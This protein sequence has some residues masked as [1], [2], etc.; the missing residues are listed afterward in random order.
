VAGEVRSLRCFVCGSAWCGVLLY[1]S[2]DICVAFQALKLSGGIA[3]KPKTVDF[4]PQSVG[5]SI[6]ERPD[7][8]S[9]SEEVGHGGP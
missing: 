4:R 2:S 1:E 8:V 5:E 9:G 6:A 3:S 7:V